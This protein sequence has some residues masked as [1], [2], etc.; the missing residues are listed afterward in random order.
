MHQ[1]SPRQHELFHVLAFHDQPVDGITMRNSYYILVYDR[2]RIQVRG[3]IMAC[4]TDDLYP[5]LI[6][7]MIRLCP[8]ESRKKGMVY[9]DDLIWIMIYEIFADNLHIPG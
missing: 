6:G 3:H 4:G 7:G 9:V 2:P 5:A 8:G 1:Y